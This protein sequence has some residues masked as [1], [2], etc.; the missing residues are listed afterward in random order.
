MQHID[1]TKYLLQIAKKWRHAAHAYCIQ[2]TNIKCS[3]LLILQIHQY[4]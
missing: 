4:H 1:A 3:F 2:Y